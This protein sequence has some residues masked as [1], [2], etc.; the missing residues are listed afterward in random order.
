MIL[1]Y[2]AESGITMRELKQSR[3]AGLL[4]KPVVKRVTAQAGGN[5]LCRESFESFWPDEYEAYLLT[6]GHW[7]A[8]KGWKNYQ[9]SRPGKNLVLQLNFS[10]KHNRQYF[11]W[12][13][14][15]GK[16]WP[17]VYWPHPVSRERVTLAWA[18]ID[19]DLDH[20]EALIE[21]IQNDWIRRVFSWNRW[22]IKNS[23]KKVRGTDCSISKL[24]TYIEKGLA[25]HL[26][27]W[28]EA[29]MAS[30][31]WFLKEELGIQRIF[32][33]TFETG[34]RLKNIDYGEP[35]RS[36]YANLP[37]RFC[38]EECGESPI[39]LR[40]SQNRRVKAHV[41]AEIAKWFVLEI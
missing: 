28:D 30:A 8:E 36:V 6:L 9:L 14:P 19:I 23:D 3:F 15:E 21:E 33:N 26:K 4:N 34:N 29:M 7:G 39:F 17:F 27:I 16:R 11:R 31:I 24:T 37:R 32:Y 1:S 12:V 22:L 18:R 5:A 13:A 20:G 38:F 2:C 35:P 40:T 10:S 25:P 41:A